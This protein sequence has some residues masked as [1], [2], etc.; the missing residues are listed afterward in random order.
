MAKKTLADLERNPK[1]VRLAE[2]LAVLRDN[3]FAVREGTRHGY[4]AIRGSQTLTIPR[5]RKIVL[6]VYVRQAIR[7]IREETR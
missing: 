3:G 4:I 6:P 2:L 5:H 7:F 1:G